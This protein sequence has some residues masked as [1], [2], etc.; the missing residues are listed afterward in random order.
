[1]LAVLQKLKLLVPSG[2]VVSHL[3][4]PLWDRVPNGTT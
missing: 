3:L 2:N 1:M 4:E